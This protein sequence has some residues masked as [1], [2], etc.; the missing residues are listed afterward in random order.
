MTLF[1]EVNYT[2]EALKEEGLNYN[3]DFILN[4]FYHWDDEECLDSEGE[5][6]SVDRI[7]ENV[8]YSSDA[9]DAVI[10]ARFKAAEIHFQREKEAKEKR[11]KRAKI[12]KAINKP[13]KQLE[14]I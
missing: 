11:L 6:I 1:E 8:G 9:V 2:L 5:D 12:Q 3:K 7:A 14:A 13:Q 10:K 4:V